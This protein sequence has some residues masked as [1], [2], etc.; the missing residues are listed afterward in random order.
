MAQPLSPHY[1]EGLLS[2]AELR[3]LTAD[4]DVMVHIFSLS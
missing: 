2:D 3:Y 4:S 1:I